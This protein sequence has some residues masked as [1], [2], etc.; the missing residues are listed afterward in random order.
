MLVQTNVL[1]AVCSYLRQRGYQTRCRFAEAAQATHPERKTL[2]I[3]VYGEN[4]EQPPHSKE[5]RQFPSRPMTEEETLD[6]VA[7]AY[8][9]A[10][11]ML[12]APDRRGNE[13]LALAFP[14]TDSFWK[15]LKYL[16]EVLDRLGIVVFLVRG[17]SSVFVL[18]GPAPNGVFYQSR[19]RILKA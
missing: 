6:C 19:R 3:S 17:D 8:Y 10:G 18:T 11:S 4:F 1:L 15:H 16:R 13:I 5:K 2:L 9:K 14:F 12:F 7:K